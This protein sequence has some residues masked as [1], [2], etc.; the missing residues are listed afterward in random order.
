MGAGESGGS[1]GA[2][3]RQVGQRRRG[4]GQRSWDMVA[5]LRRGI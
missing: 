2:G 3:H 5:V 4:G 1:R